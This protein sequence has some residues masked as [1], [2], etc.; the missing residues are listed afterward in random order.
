M[1]WI[2]F[3]ALAGGLFL[4]ARRNGEFSRKVPGQLDFA[5]AMNN[6]FIAGYTAKGL[7][8]NA[9][10][11]YETQRLVYSAI[12]EHLA[13]MHIPRGKF[14]DIGKT[15]EKTIEGSA[16]RAVSAD[17]Q[18]EMTEWKM[19]SEFKRIFGQVV[20]D[21]DQRRNRYAPSGS[22]QWDFK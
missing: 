9:E 4:Y 11:D 6:L 18:N 10:V 15:I 2:I 7:T 16:I 13:N 1:E 12:R 22:A 3:I 20:E 5:K 21:Y 19:A 14:W 17:R 8:S